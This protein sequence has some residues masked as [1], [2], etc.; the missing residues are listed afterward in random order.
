MEP[1]SQAS[2]VLLLLLTGVSVFLIASVSLRL[3]P[4]PSPFRS[5][6]RAP[7]FVLSERKVTHRLRV[8]SHVHFSRLTRSH[9]VTREWRGERREG[10]G[11]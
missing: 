7:L 2:L 11:E 5:S 6:T 10:G 3:F 9:Q 1:A 8:V 4:I